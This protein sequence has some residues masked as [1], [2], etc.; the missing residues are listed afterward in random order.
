MRV[1]AQGRFGQGPVE[2][3][4]LPL[5]LAAEEAKRLAMELAAAAAVRRESVRW[6]QGFAALALAPGA[7]VTLPGRGAV[8]RIGERTI[9]GAGVLLSL[10]EDHVAASVPV[11]ADAG[12]VAGSPDLAIGATQMALFDLPAVTEVDRASGRLV[13][14]AAGGPGWRGGFVRVRSG[15]GAPLVDVGAVGP[16]A[17]LGVVESTSVARSCALI[18]SHGAIV[19]LL[20]SAAMTL[21]N[22]SDADLVAGANL[23]V[24]GGEV[25][26]FGM[27]EPLGAN[28]WRLTRLL[29]G[30]LGTED[31]AGMQVAGDGFALLDDPALMA[32]P[33]QVGLA[34]LGVG[35]LV[36]VEGVGDAAP[37]E[38]V[39]A[40][41]GRAARP[42]SPVHLRAEWQSNGSL[43]LYWTQR[44]R[45]GFAWNDSVDVPPDARDERY[46]VMWS[47]GALS[48]A[49]DVY[50]P[51]VSLSAV[52]VAALRGAGSRLTVSVTQSG[53]VAQSLPMSAEIDLY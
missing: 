12:R 32:L 10:A 39:I 37:V 15:A 28:R 26:Q 19:V 38:R 45:S 18:D 16:V 50:H 29:R 44:S 33:P 14:A 40:L 1:A 52:A 46:R 6:P 43:V 27:A 13:L 34:T 25:L 35:G 30:R 41:Y 24:A 21:G 48:E 9:D 17:V 47:A 53:D 31:A 3:I 42:L 11:A 8:L 2:R 36:S 51:M 49:V 4:G 7:R 22:A 20:H 5:A 23:A